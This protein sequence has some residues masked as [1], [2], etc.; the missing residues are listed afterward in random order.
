M[1]FI[2]DI[3]LIISCILLLVS[4]NNLNNDYISITCTTYDQL[5]T[6]N[7]TTTIYQYIPKTGK[8]T[9][10]FSFPYTSQYPLGV[11]DSHSNTVYYTK[12]DNLN[13]DQIF[14]FNLKTKESTQLTNNLRAVNQIVPT[15]DKIFFV[16]SINRVLR[17]GAIDKNS[18]TVSYWGDEDTNVE[19][20]T[21]NPST[22]KIYVSFFSYKEDRE[23][24]ENQFV[25]DEYSYSV[26]LFSISETDYSFMNTNLI[27]SGHAW[28]RLLMIDP[29]NNNL[30]AIYDKEYNS[31][32]DSMAVS[33]NTTS[34]EIKEFILPPERM[35]VDGG[36]FSTDGNGVYVL[37]VINDE[38]GIYYFDFT[39]KE[40]IPI[41]ISENGFV[42]NFQ[43][44]LNVN[45]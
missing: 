5:N 27:M 42:N 34:Y 35:Q 31:E 17:L 16:A 28:I 44:F 29:T 18:G 21:I 25:S 1:K 38:R 7:M 32:E 30:I 10:V 15:K 13:H 22:E 3:L 9:E 6:E 40:Y 14:S 26:P 45:K 36:C 23:A 39:A 2:K 11:F 8:T 24:I 12:R 20:I 4:C 43:S 19:T 37:S 41:F 33:I